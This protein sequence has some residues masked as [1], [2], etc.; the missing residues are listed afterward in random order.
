M[1]SCRSLHD[2][3]SWNEGGGS[4]FGVGWQQHTARRWAGEFAGARHWRKAGS[5]RG[6]RD[7][8]RDGDETGARRVVKVGCGEFAR[9]ATRAVSP[10][11]GCRWSAANRAVTSQRRRL[12]NR[13]RSS[14]RTREAY[15]LISTTR[16][17]ERD[18]VPIH[19]THIVPVTRYPL[20]GTEVTRDDRGSI[21][22]TR[23]PWP[24]NA[25]LLLTYR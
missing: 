4:S 23:Y 20:V 13:H 17:A 8:R 15:T 7:G 24:P 10:D 19:H 11:L 21:I 1:R 16:R 25:L 6:R 2:V 3:T 12:E 14:P 22:S 18:V 5:G 9:F